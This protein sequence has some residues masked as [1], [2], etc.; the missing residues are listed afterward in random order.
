MWGLGVDFILR[1]LEAN[2]E[3]LRGVKGLAWVQPHFSTLTHPRASQ[4]SPAFPPSPRP[5]GASRGPVATIHV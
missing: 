3:E 1:T 2:R 5:S 4:G